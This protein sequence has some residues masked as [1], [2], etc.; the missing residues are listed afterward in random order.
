MNKEI[1]RRYF[2]GTS[3]R[4]ETEQVLKY[5]EGDD[6]HVLDEYI[7][8][9]S[10]RD[11]ERN[12]SVDP[13]IK[14]RFYARLK[15]KMYCVA[16]RR[17]LAIRVVQV[18]AV[19]AVFLTAGGLLYQRI[20]NGQDMEVPSELTRIAN[21]GY[22]LKKLQL[23]DGTQVWMN[24]GAVLTFDKRQ[25]EDTLRYVQLEGEAFFDVAHDEHRPFVVDAQGTVTRV[26]GTAFHI[27][28]YCN[29][30][31]ARI[32][33]VRGSVSVQAGG[34]DQVLVPGQA[35]RYDKNTHETG[36]ATIGTED[37]YAQYTTGK[38][39]FEDVPLVQVLNRLESAFGVRIKV[40]QPESLKE[41]Y[42]TGSYYRSNIELTLERILFIHGLTYKKEG[43]SA[44]VISK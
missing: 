39:V 44:Y 10:L 28:A 19:F 13:V 29:E 36:I 42:I 8:E 22:N 2:E 4:W 15:K 5:L 43:E 37:K 35:L 21:T 24:P 38:L 7:R 17:R 34:R 40:E 32:L 6:L 26:L 3:S 41:K 33:L 25:F 20:K 11:Q 1:L 16:E 31:N 18:A 14:D 9:Q 23:T 30:P 27:E 12:K